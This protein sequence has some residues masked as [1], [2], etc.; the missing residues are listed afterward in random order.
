MHLRKIALIGHSAAGKSACL[1]ELGIDYMKADMDEGL[2]RD[3][4]PS[5][6]EAMRWLMN[7]TSDQPIVVVS[8]H[9]EMLN[10]MLLAKRRGKEAELFGCIL[11]MYLR[12]PKDQLARD[13]A[14]PNA[15]ERCRDLL[16]QNYTLDCYDQFDTM[17]QELAGHTIDCTNK[18][19]VEVAAEVVRLSKSLDKEFAKPVGLA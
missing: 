12:K 9:E 14:K 13:L 3:H 4:C 18:G 2:G 17:F 5:L 6:A 10:E 16:S 15:A 1:Q 7:E 8:N 11:F 19:V